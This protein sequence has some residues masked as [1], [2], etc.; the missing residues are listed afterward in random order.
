M[1]FASALLLALA[2]AACT[3]TTDA[4]SLQ[5]GTWTG[6]LVP[7]NHPDMQ[8]PIR[9]DVRRDGGALAID[10]TGPD[11]QAVAARDIRVEADT[12]HF[13][14]NEPE[15]NV[16]LTCALARQDDAR[17]EGRCTDAG[18]KWARFIM[19]PPAGDEA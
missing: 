4:P 1:R 6:G 14:F 7:M 10:I 15:R 16:P 19:I 18:G 12:L 13:V 8:T 17:Y 9:Y 11:G 5:E 2:L 3:S